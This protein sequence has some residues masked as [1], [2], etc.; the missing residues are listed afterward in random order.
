MP[1]DYSFWRKQKYVI[2]MWVIKITLL[3]HPVA[4]VS[5]RMFQRIARISSISTSS[6]R[7]YECIYSGTSTTNKCLKFWCQKIG[8]CTCVNAHA[9]L[10]DAATVLVLRNMR[11]INRMRMLIKQNVLLTFITHFLDVYMYT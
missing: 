5:S 9:H 6:S 8:K 1:F 3:P 4:C 7:Y 11:M 10:G 2:A